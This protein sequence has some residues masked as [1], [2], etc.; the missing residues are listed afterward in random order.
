MHKTLLA[1]LIFLTAG[2]A[3]YIA[4]PNDT[5]RLAHNR[6]KKQEKKGLIIAAED[7]SEYRKCYRYFY[8]DY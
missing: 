8:T 6:I 3:Y 5:S 7:Y 2:C 4:L 1:C